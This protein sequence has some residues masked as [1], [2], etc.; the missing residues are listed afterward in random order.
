MYLKT[1][2][3]AVMV[4]VLTGG[5][6]YL[7]TAP[8]DEV[9]AKNIPSV[10]IKVIPETSAPVLSAPVLPAIKSETGNEQKTLEGLTLETGR[11]AS[12]NLSA[13]EVTERIKALQN[14]KANEAN[15]KQ[16]SPPNRGWVDLTKPA[17]E[18]TEN[19]IQVPVKIAK[20]ERPKSIG[21]VLN[22]GLEDAANLATIEEQDAAHIEL[23]K[24]AVEGEAYNRGVIML[25]NL[26]SAELRDAAKAHIA[27]G[28]MRSGQLLRGQGLLAKVE[29]DSAKAVIEGQLYESAEKIAQ[30][31]FK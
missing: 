27:V 9:S 20:K 18:K 6:I 16:V 2:I 1:S 31:T 7:G 19:V 30:D 15:A 5:F 22:E 3:A 29:T 12:L 13:R 21:K 26:S 17:S 11:G 4:M 23:I 24:L 10:D 8:E 28:L 14:K 25:E